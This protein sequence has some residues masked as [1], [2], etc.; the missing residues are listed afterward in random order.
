MFDKLTFA[1]TVLEKS[2]VVH[3]DDIIHLAERSDVSSTI[4]ASE[5]TANQMRPI[6]LNQA[7]SAISFFH[8]ILRMT[9]SA[10]NHLRN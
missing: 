6:W 3:H 8:A 1:V 7:F 10:E 5:D 4:P 9:K 2:T